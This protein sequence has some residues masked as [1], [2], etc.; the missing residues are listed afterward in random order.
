MAPNGDPVTAWIESNKLRIKR[1]GSEAVTVA[2]VGGISLLDLD[3]GPSTEEFPG[4]M[5]LVTWRQFVD[6]GSHSCCYQA[7][8]A[9]GS[10]SAMGAPIELSDELEDVQNN[11][12]VQAAVGPDGTAYAAWTRYDGEFWTP[13]AA[14][15]PPGGDFSPVADDLANDGDA[16]VRDLVTAADGRAIVAFD[17]IDSE[18]EELYWRAAT[19]IYVPPPP[20]P[21]DPPPQPGSPAPAPPAAPRGDVT[22]PKLKVN[23]SRKT[24]AVGDKLNQVAVKR[25]EGSYVWKSLRATLKEGT[26]LLV[27]LDEPASLAIRVDKLGCYTAKPPN[28]ARSPAGNCRKPDANVQHLRS[29]GKGGAQPPHLPGELEGGQGQGRGGV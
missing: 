5:V 16:L 19:A 14:V 10:G 22:P 29:A 8:A 3:V 23:V 26:R 15:R 13:Q 24:F 4:G 1:G 12:A 21:K 20:P 27:H 7:R 28:P 9:V 17:Q 6:D 2:D 25:G 18:G 11:P